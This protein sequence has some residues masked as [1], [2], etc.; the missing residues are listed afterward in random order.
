MSRLPSRLRRLSTAQRLAAVAGPA[1]LV[2][3]T[4]LVAFGAIRRT[5]RATERVERAHLVLSTMEH[6]LL[7]LS[8]A[9]SAARGFAVG[10]GEHF[11]EP[12][13][14]ARDD[15]TRDLQALRALVADERQRR[16]LEE[17]EPL[18]EAKLAITDRTIALVRAGAPERARAIVAS[19][20]GKEA[21]D[22]VRGAV[23][24]FS[25]A[26]AAVA[27]RRDARLEADARRLAGVVL[28]GTALAVLFAAL[29]NL[30]L[31]RH[32][33]AQEILARDLAHSNEQLR[34]Q[35]EELADQAEE[36]QLQAT[37][38]EETMM[39]LE[40]TNED[41]QRANETVTQAEREQAATAAELR[42]HQAL[43]QAVLDQMPAG[44][45]IAEAGS[46]RLLYHNGEGERLL[47]RPHGPAPDFAGYAEYG[48]VHPDGTPY[49][50]EEYPLA[51]ALLRQEHVH[52]EEML[53]RRRDDGRLTH[54]LVS[55]VPVLA[56]D[57]TLLAG[58]CTF[59]DISERKRNE[60]ELRAARAEAEE[61]NRAKM[62]F[63]TAMSHELRTP[64]NAIAGYVDLLDMDI[65]GPVSE[66]QAGALERIRRN[67]VHLLGL[68][69]DILNFA[70]IEVGHLPFEIEPLA[71]G[72]VLAAVEATIEPQVRQAGLRYV[73]L[74]CDQAV[75][76][77]ADWERTEQILLNL[78]VNAVK[79]TP[80]DGRVEAWCEADADRVRIRVRDTGRGI[81]PDK[82]QK[83]FDPFVQVDRHRTEASLQGVGLGLSISRELARQMG[84]EI[85]VETA[86]D[87]GSTFTLD[88]PRAPESDPPPQRGAARSGG[89]ARSGR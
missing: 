64:L 2:L 88:L 34:R 4:G 35:A 9:E 61:A 37:H 18:V 62:D 12:Y 77:W 28:G 54:L 82:V 29:T 42:E 49:A 87:R 3:L 22:Q 17:I 81:P 68:I 39:E 44:V 56:S 15:V 27:A 69:T 80:R 66:A 21:M 11:L 51:R 7:R 75:R 20:Q 83:I 10:G 1:L 52:G 36:L 24:E 48:A 89:R 41:L 5:V 60:A 72:E 6:V 19:G 46:G 50:A 40:V 57:G 84:G 71:V 8:D 43:L 86:V 53:C 30:L 33:Q 13:A 76:V 70:R 32:A 58:V 31:A 38:L 74:G 67:Q 59:H 85:G 55:A 23:R 45:S 16:R 26:Q 63:L 79:F 73:C 65:Y 47:G 14:G 25:A 78:L